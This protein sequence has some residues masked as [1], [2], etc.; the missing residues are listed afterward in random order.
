MVDAAWSF[1]K[2]VHC[3]SP[4]DPLQTTE[5]K[6]AFCDS[7]CQ[8]RAMDI[9]YVRGVIRSARITDY[10]TALVVYNNHINFFALDLA[11]VRPRLPE[12]LREEV[13]AANAGLCVSCNV[14]QATEVDHIRGG[15]QERH[16]LQGLCR[17]CHECKPRGPI[18][19]DLT[20]GASGVIDDAET[21]ALLLA[22]WYAAINSSSWYEPATP[23]EAWQKLLEGANT[24]AHTRFGAL[25]LS[26]LSEDIAAPSHDPEWKFRWRDYQR[27]TVAW[28]RAQLDTVGE[29]AQHG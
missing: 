16:N 18:P 25:T 10:M 21:N 7:F 14:R 1:G 19:D 8:R 6:A 15:G 12:S 20:R 22:C 3:L 29:A 24:L 17:L 28:A 11:Y 5:N 2:C 26:L 13:L 23:A 9:R 4:L 27:K